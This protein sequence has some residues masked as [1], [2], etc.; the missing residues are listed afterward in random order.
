MASVKLSTRLVNEINTVTISFTFEGSF[1]MFSSALRN[2]I[3]QNK[4]LISAIF[5][6]MFCLRIEILLF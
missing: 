3:N 5:I 1:T 6:G 2:S 4:K